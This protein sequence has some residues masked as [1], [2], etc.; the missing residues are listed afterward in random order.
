MESNQMTCPQCGLVNNPLAEECAQCGIIFVKNNGM[1]MQTDRDEQKRKAIEEAEA[2]LEQSDPAAQNEHAA[3]EAIARPDPAEDT[4]E[5]PIPVEHRSAET[6]SETRSTDVNPPEENQ[7]PATDEIEIEA[8]ETSIEMV[9]TDAEELFLSE[10]ETKTSF[11]PQKPAAAE[12]PAD[13]TTPPET[14]VEKSDQMAKSSVVAEEKKDEKKDQPALKQTKS[15][16]AAAAQPEEDQQKKEPA[17][18][19]SEV[20]EAEKDGATQ[21]AKAKT[22]ASEIAEPA[23]TEESHCFLEQIQKPER[24]RR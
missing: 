11:E 3:K 20:A 15:E 4:V 13:S 5:M 18:T 8:I 16:P 23:G 21:L 2:I 7:K 6:P 19:K 14:A 22:P 17:E 9:T 24:H 1:Q 10:V 12:Q